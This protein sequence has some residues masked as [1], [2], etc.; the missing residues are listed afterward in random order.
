MGIRVAVIDDCRDIVDTTCLAL[1][2]AGHDVLPLYTAEDIVSEL[3]LFGPNALLMDMMMPRVT[4]LDAI[5]FVRDESRLA[6]MPAICMSSMTRPKD[7]AAALRAGFDLYLPKPVAFGALIELLNCVDVP[8]AP[9]LR[10]V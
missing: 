4:G 10:A 6:L 8:P 7:K 9:N 2:S 1:Q 5:K 3:L